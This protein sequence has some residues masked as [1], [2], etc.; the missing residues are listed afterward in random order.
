M[1]FVQRFPCLK[2]VG[3]IFCVA[4]YIGSFASK[5]WVV[6]ADHTIQYGLWTWCYTNFTDLDN[7]S[8]YVNDTRRC[9]WIAPGDLSLIH[10]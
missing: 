10:I 3:S 7:A 9:H 8:A 5:G 4:I 1:T 6:V 2:I